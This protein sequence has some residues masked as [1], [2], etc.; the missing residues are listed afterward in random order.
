MR[1][2]RDAGHAPSLILTPNSY[3]VWSH[4]SAN[5]EE[6]EQDRLRLREAGVPEELLRFIR[7][8][9]EEAVVISVPG[10]AEDA[11]L[12][13]DPRRVLAVPGQDRGGD[14]LDVAVSELDPATVEAALLYEEP[15]LSPRALA[16][17]LDERLQEIDV[18]VSVQGGASIADGG[19]FAAVAVDPSGQLEHPAGQSEAR[20]AILGLDSRPGT[21][22]WVELQTSDPSAAGRYYSGLFGWERTDSPVGE[23]VVD[24]VMSLGGRSVAGIARREPAQAD[25]T[26][27]AW[28]VYMTVTSADATLERAQALGA[29]VLAPAFDVLDVGRTGL[30][31]DPQGAFVTIWEPKTR[32]EGPLLGA[33]G[34]PSFTE[35]LTSDLEGAASFYG[36]LFGWTIAPSGDTQ[37]PCLA[38]TNNGE[39]VGRMRSTAAGEP[40]RW[41]VYFGVEDLDAALTTAEELEGEVLTGPIEIGY[42]VVAILQD[43]HGAMFGVTALSDTAILAGL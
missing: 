35:L 7:G 22:G 5:S 31:Q 13:L 11:V 16:A 43:P 1:G 10:L 25:A 40:P 18:I 30:I 23:D 6:L 15:G 4:L 24:S 42:E 29:T 34:A 27:S 26:S 20:P 21:V 38:I 3:A 33:P 17:R 28:S 36:E 41:I 32:P 8:R 14:Q 19:A 9:I 39:P 2:L 12:V 37:P